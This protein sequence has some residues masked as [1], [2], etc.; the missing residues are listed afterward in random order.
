MFVHFVRIEVVQ[1]F[2][3]RMVGDD[4]KSARANPDP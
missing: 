2:I 3:I 1:L 4:G